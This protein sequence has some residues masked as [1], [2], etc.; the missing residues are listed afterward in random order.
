[1]EVL[2][3]GRKDIHFFK[4]NK[5]AFKCSVCVVQF[6]LWTSM[7]FPA[8]IGR[9]KMIEPTGATQSSVQPAGM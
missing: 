4:E 9:Q 5:Y 2:R 1:M 6:L 3:E 8:E 7:N